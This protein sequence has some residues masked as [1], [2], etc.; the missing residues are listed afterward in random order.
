MKT[1]SFQKSAADVRIPSLRILLGMKARFLSGCGLGM[2]RAARM[3]P[4]AVSGEA[5]GRLCDRRDRGFAYTGPVC[6]T[7]ATDLHFSHFSRVTPDEN[8]EVVE[9]RTGLYLRIPCHPPV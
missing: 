8:T 4:R 5:A 1:Q 2:V 7:R 6:R 9:T 3:A